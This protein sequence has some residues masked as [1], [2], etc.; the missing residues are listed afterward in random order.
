MAL[1]NA[2]TPATNLQ[3]RQVCVCK[4]VRDNEMIHPALWLDRSRRETLESQVAEPK[5]A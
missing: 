5:P 1:S 2:A 3:C 4:N